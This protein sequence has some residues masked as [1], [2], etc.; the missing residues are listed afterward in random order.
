[1]RLSSANRNH[2]SQVVLEEVVEPC[3][4]SIT[5]ITKCTAG[6]GTVLRT[7]VMGDVIV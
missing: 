2:K 5:I 3:S 7:R 1:M 4:R 6:D